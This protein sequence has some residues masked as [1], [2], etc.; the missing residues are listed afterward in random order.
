MKKYRIV[1]KIYAND[2]LTFHVQTPNLFGIWRTLGDWQD[3]L[4]SR[5]TYYDL[6]GARKRIKYEK[7]RQLNTTVISTEIVE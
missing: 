3:G 6:E 4:W 1:K 7:E 5:S 2:R